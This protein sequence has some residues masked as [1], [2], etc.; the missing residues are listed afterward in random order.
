LM[1]LTPRKVSMTL[2]LYNILNRRYQQR[3][4][5]M[6]WVFWHE[7]TSSKTGEKKIGPYQE[8][9]KFMKTLCKKADVR[10]FRFH[11]LRHCGASLLD[12][13]NVPIGAIQRV[14]GHESRTTTEIY[15]HSIGNTERDAINIFEAA[16][17]K[18]LTK[19]LP[20]KKEGAAEI[21]EPLEITGAP[22]RIRT[23]GLRI[24][25]PALYPD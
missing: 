20:S 24:R 8:R 11:A 14:L 10:Y 15:L 3:R 7:C 4:K 9:K 18:S 12:N 25:S 13:N 17:E 22:G 5:D 21:G 23:C 6:P 19:S 16:T 2:R 1:H